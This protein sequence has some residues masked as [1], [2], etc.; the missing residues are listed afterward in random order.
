[1]AAFD[2]DKANQPFVPLKREIK[3]LVPSDVNI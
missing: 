2:R 1:M 3:V